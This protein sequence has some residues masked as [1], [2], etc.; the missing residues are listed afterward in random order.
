N[1][2]H[3]FL[4]KLLSQ[5]LIKTAYNSGL[6]KYRHKPLCYISTFVQG[7]TSPSHDTLAKMPYGNGQTATT[8]LPFVLFFANALAVRLHIRCLRHYPPTADITNM[9]LMANCYF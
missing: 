4:I 3:C 6:A 2:Y 1:V 7:G 8:L 5:T 9:R